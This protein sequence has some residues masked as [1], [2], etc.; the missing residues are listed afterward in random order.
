MNYSTIEWLK[1]S[2]PQIII[3]ILILLGFWLRFYNFGEQS[4]WI[5]EGSTV[6]TVIQIEKTGDSHFQTNSYNCGLYCFPTAYIAESF[7]G[8]PESMRLLSVIFGTAFIYLL[9][10]FTKEILGTNIALLSSFLVTFSYID[11]AWSRQARWYSMFEFFFWAAFLFYF[12]YFE[13]R[14][15]KKVNLSIF[16]ITTLISMSIHPLGFLIPISL[17][18]YSYIQKRKLSLEHLLLF[19]SIPIMA[20]LTSSHSLIKIIGAIPFSYTLPYYISYYLLNYWPIII[21]ALIALF[22]HQK[23]KKNTVFLSVVIMTSLIPLSFYGVVNYR[24]AFHLLP[25]T[26]ILASIGLFFVIENI[27]KKHLKYLPV[28]IF[29]VALI[30]GNFTFQPKTEYFLESDTFQNKRPKYF[31]TP[32]PDYN[33]IFSYIRENKKDDDVTISAHPQMEKIYLGEAGY[34][35]KY[36]TPI[37][38]QVSGKDPFTGADLLENISE[39]ESV[40]STKHGYVVLDFMDIDG[41]IDGE[42]L[43]FI[44]KKM[45]LV[46]FDEKNAHSK[47]WVYKF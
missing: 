45:N 31:Y 24:Y 20:A 37:F 19:V 16:I 15:N 1:K 35:L 41:N 46:L 27:E 30:F 5:D 42:T 38:K 34:L 3:I 4:Y 40:V 6:N 10:V 26:F 18:V 2:S 12:R 14:G 11:I 9:Y 8:S 29:I 21:F 7:G 47:L 44:R 23:K 43:D 13:N 22:A 32:Q 17:I 36:N 33:K 25:A 39:L 28:V